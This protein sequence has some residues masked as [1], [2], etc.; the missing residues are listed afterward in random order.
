MSA[1]AAMKA[2]LADAAFAF[3]VFFVGMI[4]GFAASRHVAGQQ[5][6]AITTERDKLRQMIVDIAV[7]GGAK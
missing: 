4:I 1:D 3:A 7:K 5:L 2:M 6:D